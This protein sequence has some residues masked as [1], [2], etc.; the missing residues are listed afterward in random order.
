MKPLYTA[1]VTASGGRDGHVKSEDGIIDFDVTT[2]KELGGDGGQATNPEQLFASGYAACF[3]GALNLMLSKAKKKAD[4]TVTA[5]V[6]IGKDE[7]ESDGL[8][9]AVKLDVSIPDMDREEAQ[10]FIEKAHA[11]CPYSK[12]TRNN[13]DVTLNLV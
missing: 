8:K 3:D 13:V 1:V 5:N 4:T 9:L 2:P 11:F 12:A 7:A 10:Q 6:S